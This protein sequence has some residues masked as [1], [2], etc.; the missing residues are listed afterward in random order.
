VPG[1][2]SVTQVALSGEGNGYAVESDGSV[3]AWGDNSH[4]QLGNG[5]TTPSYSPVRLPILTGITQVSSGGLESY[6][7][8]SDGPLFSWGSNGSGEQWPA[9]P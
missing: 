6:A 7:V 8:R 1:L 2:S 3:W 5:T 9:P 4:A